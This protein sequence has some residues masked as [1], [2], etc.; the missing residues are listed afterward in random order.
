MIIYQV[1]FKM[2]GTMKLRVLQKEVGGLP[3]K[4]FEIANSY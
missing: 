2:M 4:T 1:R 3:E